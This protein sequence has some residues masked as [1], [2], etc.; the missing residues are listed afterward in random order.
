MSRTPRKKRA[1]FGFASV[2]L[3][4]LPRQLDFAGELFGPPNAVGE[5][6]RS[7]AGA[8]SGDTS[9]TAPGSP[10]A[11]FV[12]VYSVKLVQTDCVIW[13]GLPRKTWPDGGVS[14]HDSERAVVT[15][16]FAAAALIEA[17]L[18]GVDREYFG[19]LLL[20]TKNR[21]IGI[22]TVS[23]G[24]L[25]STLVH[26]RE[27][28]KP[29]VLANA[30]SVLLFHNHPSGNLD[31]S[32]EDIAVTN[33]LCDAGRIMGIDVVDHVVLGD[34][35][36]FVS[37][38]N[39]N[40]CDFTNE[41]TCWSTGAMGSAGSNNTTGNAH[42]LNKPSET[43]RVGVV[44]PSDALDDLSDEDL[45]DFGLVV[46]TAAGASVVHGFNPPQPF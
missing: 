28:F 5:A 26:P 22:N 12:P 32:P 4:P 39:K 23:V 7:W 40:L 18:S 35:G 27:A 44:G 11:D 24:D 3:F 16:P 42:K 25:C 38:R 14:E 43:Q 30:A 41:F 10:F 31:P 15:N 37:L 45:A 19:L 2:P 6:S 34:K 9:D 1:A 29:A 8:A 46:I 13:R 17:H 36:N 20:D 33:R 21:V